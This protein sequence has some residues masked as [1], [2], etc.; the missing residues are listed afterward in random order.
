MRKE[1]VKITLRLPAWIPTEMGAIG[2]V[3]QKHILDP[4]Y[5]DTLNFRYDTMSQYNYMK[6][7]IAAN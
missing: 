1:E 3:L 4:F 6:E 2:G 7:F 5:F